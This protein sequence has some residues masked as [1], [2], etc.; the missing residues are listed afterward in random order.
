VPAS[1]PLAS[2][3]RLARIV[4]AAG[5]LIAAG[6]IVL[7]LV[8]GSLVGFAV[9]AVGVLVALG[10]E[11]RRSHIDFLEKRGGRYATASM[12]GASSWLPSRGGSDGPTL[13][14]GGDMLGSGGDGGGGGGGE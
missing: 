9:V 12:L 6:G 14:G 1:S 7:V 10:A 4:L 5:L 3:R 8:L 11:R 2:P 13:G